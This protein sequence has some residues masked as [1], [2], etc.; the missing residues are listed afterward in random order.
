MESFKELFQG[1][2]FKSGHARLFLAVLLFCI[3]LWV[4]PKLKN[5]LIRELKKLGRKTKTEIDDLLIGIL[6]EIG[7]FFFFVFAVFVSSRFVSL[8]V[9]FQKWITVVT[10]AMVIFQITKTAVVLANFGVRKIAERDK[11]T[12]GVTRFLG[13]FANFAIWGI[14][15]LFFLQNLGVNISSLVAGL[16]I[17]GIA[18]ALAAQ[19]IL[20]DVFASFSIFFDRP[21]RVGDFVK[22]GDIAGTVKKIGIKT[23][24]FQSIDGEEIVVPNRNLT[25]SQISNFQKMKRRRGRFTIGVE[26]STPFSKL[27]EIPKLVKGVAKGIAA[28]EIDRVS[29]VAFGDFSLNFEI[30]FWVEDPA[31]GEF[32]RV[33]ERLNLA[34]F[35]IFEKEQIAFAFPTQTIFLPNNFPVKK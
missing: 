22:I 33:Q 15:L 4:L 11:E 24:R 29:F 13:S 3:T 5:R 16:G 23:T 10:L 31:F 35:E 30:V 12:A 32:R 8:P 14:G 6:E 20:S 7:G 21:F 17:S 34:I 2:I 9:N 27:K 19:T 25:E 28:L 18:V 1:E 26:Y